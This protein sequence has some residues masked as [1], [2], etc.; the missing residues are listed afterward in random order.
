VDGVSTLDHLWVEPGRM[1]TGLGTRLF[2]HAA[3]AAREMDA[4]EMEWEG[5]PNAVGFY[6]RM[7]GR[8]VRTVTSEWNRTLDVMAVELD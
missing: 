2:R 8:T 7:G 6:E 4:S 3:G 5:E 1:R